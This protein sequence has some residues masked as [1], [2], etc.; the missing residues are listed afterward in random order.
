M[1]PPVSN[2]NVCTDCS[3]HMLHNYCIV[4]VVKKIGGDPIISL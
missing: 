4:L 3:D 2:G 1:I